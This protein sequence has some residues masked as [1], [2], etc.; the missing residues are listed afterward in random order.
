MR[1]FLSLSSRWSQDPLSGKF[2]GILRS[3]IESTLTMFN[4][5]P[6][7]RRTLLNQLI[8]MESAALEVLNRK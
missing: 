5:N 6:G 3:D 7:K 2:S 8:M 4:I 1:I